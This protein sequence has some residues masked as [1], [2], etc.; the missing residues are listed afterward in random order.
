VSPTLRTPAS[1]LSYDVLVFGPQLAGAVTAALLA[2]RGY[3]VLMVAHGAAPTSYRDGAFLLPCGPT[4]L[5]PLKSMPV[6]TAVL[7][8]L[9]LATDVLRA[10]TPL[11]PPLQILGERL[12]LD[13]PRETG[14]RAEELARELGAAGAGAAEAIERLLQAEEADSPFFRLS[15]PLPAQGLLER[16]QL[17]RALAGQ[18]GVEAGAALPNGDATLTRSLRE[19]WHFGTFLWDEQPPSRASLRP[20]AQLLRGLSTYPRGLEGLAAEVRKRV[21]AAGGEVVEG[22]DEPPEIEELRLEGGRIAAAKLEGSPHEYRASLFVAATGAA[23]LRDLLPASAGESKLAALL[24]GVKA[25]SSLLTLNLVVGPNG[26]PAGLGPAALWLPARTDAPSI[27]VQVSPAQAASGSA[28]AGTHVVQLSRQVP[29]ALFHQGE[30]H[31]KAVLQEM[32]AG[33]STF[34]PFVDRHVVF[35]SSPHLQEE[36]GLAARLRLHPLVEVGLPRQLGVTGLPFRPP[37]KNLVLASRDVLPGLGLE[38]ELLAGTRAAQL[39]QKAL[40]KKELLR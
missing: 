30:G 36:S 1:R 24:G 29:A 8:E 26:L 9:G 11:T 7:E 12:R 40:P 17:R 35:E 32:R 19:L 20:L 18:G 34:L 10:L 25:R 39:V 6:A 22:D 37:C 2:R 33:A 3:R 38:G 5:P 13:L 15:P 16:W 21:T 23:D 31:V 14:P 27:F 4:V 28:P